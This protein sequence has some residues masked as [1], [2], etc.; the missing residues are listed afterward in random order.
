MKNFNDLSE[1]EVLALAVSLEEEE[2]ERVY[3]DFAEGLKDNYPASSSLFD[4]MRSE[5]SQSSAF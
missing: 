1:R 3:A 4:A 2:E 5:E